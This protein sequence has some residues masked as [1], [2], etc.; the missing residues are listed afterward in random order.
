MEVPYEVSVFL[1]SLNLEENCLRYKVYAFYIALH[2]FT[3]FP[4]ISKMEVTVVSTCRRVVIKRGLDLCVSIYS[5][6][7]FF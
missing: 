4:I 2:E 6:L 3:L 7:S 5:S 1:L